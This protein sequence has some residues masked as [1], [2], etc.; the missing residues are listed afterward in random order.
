MGVW[1][2]RRRSDHELLADAAAN[3][4]KVRSLHI[5][6]VDEDR[7]G[8]FRIEADILSSGVGDVSLTQ[9][10]LGTFRVRKT[11]S[12][13]FLRGDRTY[14]RAVGGTGKEGAAAA[15]RLAGRWIR[16]AASDAK[17]FSGLFA[18]LR[19]KVLAKCVT[20]EGVTGT[21]TLGGAAKVGG[22]DATVLVVA[23]D[24]PGTAPGR[25]FLSTGSAPLPLRAQVTGPVRPGGKETACTDPK[26]TTTSSDV[27]F[28]KIDRKLTIRAPKNAIRIPSTSG[29]GGSGAPT[30]SR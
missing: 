10:K 12:A 4:A 29:G 22:T 6:S 19:P 24:L 5:S 14:W 21:L 27:R 7:D 11:S 28:S 8:T 17:E 20:A 26:S 13:T 25:I 1:N 9:P 3:L 16:V 30:L 15:R 2:S 23:G 18:E